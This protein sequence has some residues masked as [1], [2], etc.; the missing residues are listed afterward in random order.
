MNRNERLQQQR[1]PHVLANIKKKTLVKTAV[2][3]VTAGLAMSA[4]ATKFNWGEIDG[5]FTSTLSLGAS[6][7]MEDPEEDYIAPGN[8]EGG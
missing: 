6:W 4:Q 5:T 8:F 7:R 1:G 2:V 3:F